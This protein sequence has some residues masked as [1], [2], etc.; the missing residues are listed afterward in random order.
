MQFRLSVFITYLSIFLSSTTAF[1]QYQKTEDMNYLRNHA[2]FFDNGIRSYEEN[3]KYGFIYKNHHL[4]LPIYDTLFKFGTEICIVKC[5]TVFKVLDKNLRNTF[6]QPIHK[7]N[8]F[9]SLEKKAFVLIIQST[10]GFT[11]EYILGNNDSRAQFTGNNPTQNPLRENPDLYTRSITDSIDRADKFPEAESEINLLT[12]ERIEGQS[13]YKEILFDKKRL[14]FFPKNGA[15]FVRERKGLIANHYLGASLVEYRNPDNQQHIIINEETGDTVLI[16]RFGFSS[17]ILN[18][19]L[20]IGNQSYG[21][22]GI[23]DNITIYN[24]AGETLQVFKAPVVNGQKNRIWLDDQDMLIEEVHPASRKNAYPFYNVYAPLSLERLLEK[25]VLYDQ[26]KDF[27]LYY[28]PKDRMFSLLKKDRLIYSFLNNRKEGIYLNTL[29]NK[30]EK[31]PVYIRIYGKK[32]Q[33]VESIIVSSCGKILYRSTDAEFDLYTGMDKS[34]I[35]M[36]EKKNQSDSGRRIAVYDQKKDSLYWFSCGNS[37]CG[38]FTKDIL[39]HSGENGSWL[40]A[41]NGDTLLT[42]NDNQFQIINLRE[43][44]FFIVIHSA[45]SSSLYNKDLKQVCANCMLHLIN[46]EHLIFALFRDPQSAVFELVDEH[47]EPVG[48]QRY[49]SVIGKTGKMIAVLTEEKKIDYLMLEK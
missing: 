48:N 3:G 20:Y 31:E 13:P 23:V 36:F 14:K 39:Y 43:N 24:T 8:T 12:N 37:D 5:D 32:E 15:P 47:L 2:V 19:Q 29:G 11:F 33:L 34:T 38:V 4:S 18:N 6:S 35:Q 40:E 27:R 7:I 44:E 22:S 42:F 45:N 21:E 46:E 28:S 41:L 9:Y 26:S 10:R 1:C 16:S 30:Y 17:F 49:L 25:V